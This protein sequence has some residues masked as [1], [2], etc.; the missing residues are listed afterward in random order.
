[1][2]FL[3]AEVIQFELRHNLEGICGMLACIS[4]VDDCPEPTVFES[5]W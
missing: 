5:K 4:F 2:H 1:M 3:N